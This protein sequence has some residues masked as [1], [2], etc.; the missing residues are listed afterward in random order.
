M[1]TFR[2]CAVLMIAGLVAWTGFDLD[3]A[4]GAWRAG[5]AAV[6]ITPKEP[7]WMSGYASRNHPAEGM[8]HDLWAKALVLEDPQGRQA[9]LVTLDL[10][11]IDRATSQNICKRLQTMFGLERSQVALATS[12]TH[13]GPVVGTNLLSMYFLD[14]A[15]SQ[16]VKDYTAELETRVARLVGD[17]LSRMKPI[18]LRHGQGT[19]SFAVNRRNNREP[20]VPQLRERGE[21]NGPVDHEL[22]VLTISDEDEKLIAVVFG[23]ACHAT[24]LDGYQWSGDWPG[25]AQLEIERRHPGALAL[26]WAGCGADQNPLPRRTVEL[27]TEYGRQTADGV[28]AVLAG[29][30]REIGGELSTRYREI[31][32]ALDDLPTRE[33]VQTDTQS[34]NR[35]VA[36]R[37]GLLLEQWD[38]D[39]GLPETYPYPVQVW[40]LGDEVTFV[41]LG[42][43][44]VVDY[45][46]R[47]KHELD[48]THTWV[49]GYANDVMAYIPSLRVLN[50]G[51]YE[52]ATA[53]IYYGLPTSWSDRVEEQI[54][55]AVHELLEA[56]K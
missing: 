37:A 49:A 56:P 19:A 33:Q 30:M 11:G 1:M 44:V 28:D 34:D 26:F 54:I 35:Y 20:D 17:A 14:E 41:I 8:L 45:S 50:E 40:R 32:L 39:G 27:G 42:G 31:D 9:V 25:F 24:V 7:M 55:G 13:S 46:I 43:E 29:P 22:P 2:R 51:G 36:S 15:N 4:E 16:R 12:H 38:R 6:K 47:L 48:N 23:Y 52:G 10:V 5:A 3:D 18:T 21:L 53:M